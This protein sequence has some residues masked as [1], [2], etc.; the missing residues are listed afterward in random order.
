[1]TLTVISIWLHIRFLVKHMNHR[2]HNYS[3]KKTKRTLRDTG[4]PES[5]LSEQTGLFRASKSN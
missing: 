1:M 4:P 5:V 2:N 3:E